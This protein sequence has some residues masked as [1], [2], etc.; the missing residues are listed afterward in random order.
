MSRALLLLFGSLQRSNVDPAHTLRLASL[1]RSRRR[2]TGGPSSALERQ[3]NRERGGDTKAM[4]S[5]VCRTLRAWQN[6]PA[7]SCYL[8]CLLVSTSSSHTPFGAAHCPRS[9]LA[10]FFSVC[11]LGGA[12]PVFGGRH[13]SLSSRLL[14]VRSVRPGCPCALHLPPHCRDSCSVLWPTR[15]RGCCHSCRLRRTGGGGRHSLSDVARVECSVLRQ[16]WT[17]AR[18]VHA[19]R[20][21]PAAE[22]RRFTVSA[23]ELFRLRLFSPRYRTSSSNEKAVRCTRPCASV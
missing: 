12:S 2:R 19:R 14:L 7:D 23:H 9:V 6:R 13:P 22:G 3:R 17:G 16:M 5:T 1:R 15:C 10:V 4:H 20:L 18:R 21:T 8:A 11:F